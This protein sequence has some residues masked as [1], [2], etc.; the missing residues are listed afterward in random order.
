MKPLIEETGQKIDSYQLD[1]EQENVLNKRRTARD[2]N[3]PNRGLMSYQL[4]EIIDFYEK[5]SKKDYKFIQEE[6]DQVDDLIKNLPF[7]IKFSKYTRQLIAQNSRIIQRPKGEFIIKQGDIGEHIYIILYGSC[8][9]LIKRRHPTQNI[10]I[11]YVRNTENNFQPIA[12]LSDGNSFGEYALMRQNTITRKET[13][14]QKMEHLKQQLKETRNSLQGIPKFVK[15][16]RILNTMKKKAK[17]EG[18]ISEETK[19][20]LLQMKEKEQLIKKEENNNFKIDNIKNKRAA[21]IQV[22]E[23]ATMIEIPNKFFV[24]VVMKIIKKEMEEKLRLLS[25]QPIF[26]VNFKF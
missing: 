19:Y 4:R 14:E 7:F 21:S 10:M 17:I 8:N 24:E 13:I 15:M 5:M 9:V 16:G 25:L 3:Q 6:F 26:D 18:E 22:V 23:S 20:D 1:I 12:C 2:K 11:D